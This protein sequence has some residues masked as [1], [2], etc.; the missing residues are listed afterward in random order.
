LEKDG[1][2]EIKVYSINGS[3]IKEIF[4]GI[5]RRGIY[6][7]LWEPKDLAQGTYFIFYRNGKYRKFEKIVYLR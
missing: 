1:N 5:K 7:I 3:K 2:V 4:S 6:K